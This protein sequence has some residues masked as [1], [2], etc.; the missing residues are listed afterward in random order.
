[1]VTNLTDYVRTYPNVLSESVCQKIIKNFV[2]SD[3]IYPDRQNRPSFRDL[4][5]SQ[6]Y[7]ATDLK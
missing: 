3:S 5:I 7:H 1:M 2:D 4:N 6:T